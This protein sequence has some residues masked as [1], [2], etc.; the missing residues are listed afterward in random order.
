MSDLPFATQEKS[1]QNI[2][3]FTTFGVSFQDTLGV[4]PRGSMIYRAVFL[5]FVFGFSA[6]AGDQEF[7]LPQK[8]ITVQVTVSAPDSIKREALIFLTLELRALGDVE[9]VDTAPRYQIEVVALETSS[10]ASTV[11]TGYAVSAIVTSPIDLS[12]LKFLFKQGGQADNAGLY[13]SLF[14]ATEEATAGHE[15]ILGHYLRIGPSDELAKLCA[16]LIATIDGETFEGYRKTMREVK[17]KL[18]EFRKEQQSKKP[19]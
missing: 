19:Q 8:S 6:L 14:K 12:L 18:E 4:I 17:Q 16:G 9:V 7:T 15:L 1:E 13:D 11:P 10:R 5:I 2:T 3:A